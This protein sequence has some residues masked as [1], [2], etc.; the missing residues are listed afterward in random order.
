[1]AVLLAAVAL[2]S[3]AACAGGDGEIVS[4]DLADDQTLRIA[5]D[6]EPDYID[7]SLAD[8]ATSVTVSKNLFATLL[9][10]DPITGE[11]TPYVAAEVPSSENGGISD[12][13]LTY[14]FNLREDA[15]WEDGQ[16]ITA[17][18]FVYAIQR[19]MDP[20]LASYY[21]MTYYTEIIEGGAD[22][23]FTAD[24][25]E[26]TI[27]QLRAA[28]KVMAVDDRTLEVTITRPSATFNLLMALWPT[29]ALRQDV[30]EQYGDITNTTW[31]EA[32]NLVASGP[33]R[34]AEWNHGN[35]IVLER[36]PNF[37]DAEMGPVLD[38]VVFQ[39]IEDENTAFAAYLAGDLDAVPVPVSNLGSIAD[40]ES[41]TNELRRVALAVTF[42]FE[43]NQTRPPFDQQGARQAFCQSIDRQTL[44]NEVQQGQGVPAT[45][46]LPKGLDPFFVDDRGQ[47]LSFDPNSAVKL[48][49]DATS[50]G[51][52]YPPVTF[53][54]ANV[55]PNPTRAQFIQGQW[56]E[57]LGIDV[58]LDPMDPPAFGEA[59]G[60]GN[61][62]IAFIGFGQDYHHPE[63]WLLMWI[64]DG[65]LNAGGYSNPEFDAT[66]DEALNETDQDE[67]VALW[68]EA[69]RILLDEDAALCPL[70]NAEN[71]WLVKPYVGDFIMTGA[72]GQPGDFFYWKTAIL[73]H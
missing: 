60:T 30:I 66:V 65:G 57:N 26:A 45:S 16:P 54:F 12:D 44:V 56:S 48:V 19:L 4:G 37:W 13:G 58:T 47:N 62:D 5:L 29:A 25:D 41:Y 59:F 8:F 6:G 55:G 28:V 15:V 10:F 38:R 32:G 39:I 53:S 52:A 67:A 2:V 49:L 1:V 18:D 40:D 23:A 50:A 27:E 61:F 33:F 22:L 20:N 3:L 64:T 24:A 14:T 72:D 63:N 68:Q 42:A 9:R 31:T 70:F 46:W 51:A 7:P 35:S 34:L 43:F 21:G 73:D 11:A 36:N 17:H 71:T 69:E